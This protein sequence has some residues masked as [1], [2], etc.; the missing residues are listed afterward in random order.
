VFKSCDCSVRNVGED[1]CLVSFGEAAPLQYV[2]NV[3]SHQLKDILLQ[4]TSLL[5]RS[6]VSC[7]GVECVA[8]VSVLVAAKDRRG[9]PGVLVAF[10]M[11][12]QPAIDAIG[13]VSAG[14]RHYNVAL[15]MTLALKHTINHGGLEDAV[16]VSGAT[17]DDPLHYCFVVPGDRF[18]DWKKKKI[19]ALPPTCA[20]KVKVFVVK[21][22]NTLLPAPGSPGSLPSVPADADDV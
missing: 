3:L 5:H 13:V 10:S 17:E 21:I 12:N 6:A 20:S 11:K 7:C 14:S 15:Q 4:G 22:G 1:P 2:R 9:V 18:E 16:D 19:L 8:V